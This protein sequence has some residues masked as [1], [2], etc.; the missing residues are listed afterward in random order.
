M[1]QVTSVKE[2]TNLSRADI[3]VMYNIDFSA[4]SYFQS[5]ARLSTIDRPKT[6]VHWIFTN[7]GIEYDIYKT[8]SN[9]KDYTLSYFK[10]YLVTLPT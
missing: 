4:T 10:K 2:G 6:E 7:G 5:R 1:G 9:K 3:L 8:V